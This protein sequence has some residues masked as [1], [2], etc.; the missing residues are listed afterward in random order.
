MADVVV[1]TNSSIKEHVINKNSRKAVYVVR[2]SNPVRFNCLEEVGKRSRDGTLNIGYFGVLANDEAAGL[3]H[4]FHMAEVLNRQSVSW[5]FSIVGD[6]PGLRYLRSVAR[7][8]HLEDRFR[9]F[10]Y[11]NIPE[12]FALI[13]DFDFGLVTWGYLPKNHMHTAMKIMD[14]MCCA[15]PVC[16]LRLKE[17]LISTQGIGVHRDS[18]EEIAE[19]LAR[20]HRALDEYETLRRATLAHF[21][22][23][24]AWE[25]QERTLCN[26]Y[27]ALAGEQTT[28]CQR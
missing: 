7:Q 26:A 20:L 12:A 25:L 10:G 23:R 17:Q 3:D 24:L 27:A 5:M 28:E 9:F 2:N 16:S 1:A 4:L 19:E 21:N 13:K 22:G 6:G 14:Y 8:K 18:F 11:V 15:V